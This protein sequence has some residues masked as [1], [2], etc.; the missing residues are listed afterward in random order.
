MTH[1]SSDW[2]RS[3]AGCIGFLMTVSSEW[4]CGFLLSLI[5]NDYK[6][7]S[8]PQKLAHIVRALIFSV[9][10]SRNSRESFRG[11]KKS[12]SS[13]RNRSTTQI[14]SDVNH[15]RPGTLSPGFSSWKE[16]NVSIPSFAW[17]NDK[18]LVKQRGESTFARTTSSE[19][20]KQ[21]TKK[22][23]FVNYSVLEAHLAFSSPF[24]F[25]AANL[26]II[27]SH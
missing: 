26:V 23:L 22:V 11:R 1:F 14:H 20:N 2:H 19:K 24:F 10:L 21:F 16:N 27:A 18:S 7:F 6:V 15:T 9:H 12:S 4:Y 5:N 25:I 3:R 17:E 8:S 13:S